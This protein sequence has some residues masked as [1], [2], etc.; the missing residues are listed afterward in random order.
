VLR[1]FDRES[2]HWVRFEGTEIIAPLSSNRCLGTTRKG[3]ESMSYR[4]TRDELYDLVWSE[5][6]VDT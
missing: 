5:P 1:A 4:F 6:S 3:D 2:P